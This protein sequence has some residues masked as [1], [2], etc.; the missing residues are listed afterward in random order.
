MCKDLKILSE[1]ESFFY[2]AVNSDYVRAL[3]KSDFE[4]LIPIYEKWTNTKADVNVNGCGT[5]KLKFMKKLGTLYFQKKEQLNNKE[6]NVKEN[7]KRNKPR[8]K[9]KN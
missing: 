3:W 4:I 6:K 2:T 1:Y 7:A 9:G 8:I 5:C